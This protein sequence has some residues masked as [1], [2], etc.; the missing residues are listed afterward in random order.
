M[1]LAKRTS[2]K[3]IVILSLCGVLFLSLP[4][5]AMALSV[6]VTPGQLDI[7]LSEDNTGS[8]L[9]ITNSSNKDAYYRIYIADA[10]YKDYFII[11]PSEFTLPGNST[12]II[13]IN[14]QDNCDLPDYFKTKISVLSVSPDSGLRCG[15]GVR[16][17]VTVSTY[18][19]LNKNMV[20]V[21]GFEPPTSW[22]QTMRASPCATPRI[23]TKV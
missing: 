6:G 9:N 1:T 17:P 14:I 3:L 2:I 5:S 11:E 23:T 19:L 13:N 4:D 8:S 12:M 7:N 10:T 22:S 20:G 15:V 18:K 21:S 16:V